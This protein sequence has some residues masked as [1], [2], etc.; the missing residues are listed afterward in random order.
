MFRLFPSFV[1]D[2][3]MVFY[4]FL[5]HEQ[6]LTVFIRLIETGGCIMSDTR[7]C[8]HYQAR[9]HIPAAAA[10]Q[11]YRNSR[12]ITVDGIGRRSFDR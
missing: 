7:S 10:A 9:A 5:V 8:R 6:E 11:A 1:A 4:S 3:D 12:E 2:A